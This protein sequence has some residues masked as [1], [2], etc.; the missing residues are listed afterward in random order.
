MARVLIVDDDA[1]SAQ[2]LSRTL[3]KSG[4]DETRVVHSAVTALR[5]AV[6]FR[7]DII[8]VDIEL[9]DMSGYDVALFLH[10]HPRLQQM[11]L[12][13]LTDSGE[14]PGREHARSSGSSAIS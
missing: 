4:H 12:I 8:F 2:V 5:S 1:E 11:R 7:P 10:Q 13:A 9:P 3:Q 6:E 14:H